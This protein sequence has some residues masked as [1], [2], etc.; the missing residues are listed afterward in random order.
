[1]TQHK[2]R[3]RCQNANFESRKVQLAHS[4][5]VRIALSV[6]LEKPS[7]AADGPV[8]AREGQ[9]RRVPVTFEKGRDVTAIPGRL[10]GG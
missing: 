1:M 4:R 9:F 7:I 3:V 10:L 2:R 5:P 8:T 6:P